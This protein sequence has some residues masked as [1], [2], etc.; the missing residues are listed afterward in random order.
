MKQIYIINRSIRQIDID[1]TGIAGM[2]RDNFRANKI[3]KPI[4]NNELENRENIFLFR[5]EKEIDESI[6]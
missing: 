5:D 3:L 4:I 1:E 6:S 2:F